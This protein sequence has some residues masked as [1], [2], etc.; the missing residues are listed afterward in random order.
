MNKT[1]KTAAIISMA[2]SGFALLLTGVFL[3]FLWEPLCLFVA[4]SEAVAEYG[5]VIPLNYLVETA[6]YLIVAVIVFKHAKGNTGIKPE[7]IS[8]VLLGIIIPALV[9]AASFIQTLA[10]GNNSD[11]LRSL[12]VA[13]TL[14]SSHISRLTHISLVLC[15]VA[16]GMSISAKTIWK[17]CKAEES[18]TAE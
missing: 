2:F 14:M 17:K 5:P 3:S 10:V 12:S 11:A 6:G 15:L 13:Q 8:I 4:G 1:I 9:R 16:C 7:I 18:Q